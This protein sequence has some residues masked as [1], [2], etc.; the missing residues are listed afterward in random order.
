MAGAKAPRLDERGELRVAPLVVELDARAQ[1]RRQRDA[2]AEDA[3]VLLER[4]V[5]Q[6][7]LAAGAEPRLHLDARAPRCPCRPSRG[8]PRRGGGRPRRSAD[9]RAGR[10]RSAASPRRAGARR[11]SA[12]SGCARRDAGRKLRSNSPR[13]RSTV[14]T[15]ESSG[16]SWMPRSRCPVRPSASTTSSNGSISETSSG[17]KRRCAAMLASARRR[18]WRAKSALAVSRG[19]PVTRP[20]VLRS[21]AQPARG[22]A[23]RQRPGDRHLRGR[24]RPA[25]QVDRRGG[26]GEAQAPG[27]GRHAGHDERDRAAARQPRDVLAARARG[28]RTCP[29]AR[30]SVSVAAAARTGRTVRAPCGPVPVTS[31]GSR[32]P[33]RRGRT[34]AR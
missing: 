9:R 18:R 2:L 22:R 20:S 10:R 8:R 26:R 19:R 12:P 6:P 24:A 7:Q 25:G 29:V 32:A 28:R 27:G 16:I 17:S 13:R 4:Q 30:T 33:R 11:R 14:P 3:L 15:I 31:P 21:A 34:A 23:A 1:R 5:A